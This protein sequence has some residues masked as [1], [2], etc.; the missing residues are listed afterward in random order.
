MTAPAAARFLGGLAVGVV[1]V[2]EG[3]ALEGGRGASVASFEDVDV[4]PLVAKILG[5]DI[6]P[7]DGTLVP[8]QSILVR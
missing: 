4:Y 1:V 2:A 6:G 5:L 8:V 3:F 7:I